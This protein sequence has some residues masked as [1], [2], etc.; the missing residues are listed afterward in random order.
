MTAKISA[1]EKLFAG[2][3]V[4]SSFAAPKRHQILDEV[5][6]YPCDDIIGTVFS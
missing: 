1:L 2:T 3:M 6:R 4:I 5:S